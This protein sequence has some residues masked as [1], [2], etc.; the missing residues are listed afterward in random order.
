MWEVLRW[1]I[2]FVLA[3]LLIVVAIYLVTGRPLPA[4][5]WLVIVQ[6]LNSRPHAPSMSVPPLIPTPVVYWN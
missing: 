1:M 4:L 6:S 3:L 5:S 2:V